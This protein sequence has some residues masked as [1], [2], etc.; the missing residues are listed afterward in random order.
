MKKEHV[1]ACKVFLMRVCIILLF[2]FIFI[3]MF[4]LID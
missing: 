3:I 4:L 2:Y 1:D